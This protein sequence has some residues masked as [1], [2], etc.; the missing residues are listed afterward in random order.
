MS[1][2][3]T[4]AIALLVS[5]TNDEGARRALEAMDYRDIKLG[6]AALIGCGRDDHASNK[7]MAKTREG[8]PV[9]GVVC[10]GGIAG[11]PFAKGC[12]VRIR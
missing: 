5:C 4:L 1:I 12:T 3:S 10:C 9:A 2:K 11:D 7:F 6:G 8:R